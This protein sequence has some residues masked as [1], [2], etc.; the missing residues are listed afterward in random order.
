MLECSPTDREHI[1]SYADL[2]Q[3]LDL[4]NIYITTV[5]R[6]LKAL[7]YCYNENKRCY[8]TDGHE[9]EYVVK[10]HENI[11]LIKYFE[12]ELRCHWWVQILSDTDKLVGQVDTSF[13]ANCSYEYVDESS[14]TKYREYHVDTHKKLL[15]YVDTDNEKIWR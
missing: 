8:Y 13:F 7:G 12:A 14:G 3:M 15:M 6:W 1:P 11:F 4:K 2:L 5:W 9:Q 10:D